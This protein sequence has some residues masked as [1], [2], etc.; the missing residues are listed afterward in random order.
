MRRLV[1]LWI[2]A[3]SIISSS[4]EV[5][6]GFN[7]NDVGTPQGTPPLERAARH[8]DKSPASITNCEP[9]TKRAAS[10]AR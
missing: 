7:T 9:V 3:A 5:V 8:R 6:A 4:E 2:V 1:Q 10:E